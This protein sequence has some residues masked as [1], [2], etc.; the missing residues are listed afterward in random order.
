MTYSKE[1]FN[2]ID[3]L[4]STLRDVDHEILGDYFY[5]WKI[6][7]WNKISNE[8]K[9]YSPEFNFYGHKWKLEL[10]PNG[11]DDFY[12]GNISLYLYRD[13]EKDDCCV[14]IAVNRV[15]FIRNY[16]DYSCFHSATLPIEYLSKSIPSSGH[17]NLINKSQLYIK[18]E[19]LN[20]SLIE[21]NRCVLGVY[22]QIYKNEK[23]LF[24]REITCYVDDED[25]V[26]KDKGFYEWKVGNWNKSRRNIPEIS[27][28]FNVGDQRW[29]LEL[30]KDG[31]G[32][33]NKKYVS[34][35][36]KCLN[37]EFNKPEGTWVNGILFIRNCDDD[38]DC[39]YFDV[40]EFRNFNVNNVDWGFPKLIK[41]KELFVKSKSS[42]KSVIENDRC[43]V[44]AYFHIY[45]D[46][47]GKKENKAENQPS[48]DTQQILPPYQNPPPYS[49]STNTGTNQ[50]LNNA[51][52]PQ[53]QPYQNSPYP[54]QQGP[55]PPYQNPPYP[56]QQGP[57]PPYQYPP[58]YYSPVNNIPNQNINNAPIQQYPPYQN[59]P[60]Q[61]TPPMYNSFQN[62]PF[63]NNPFQNNLFQN[64]PFQNNPFQNASTR[65]APT[66]DNQE[67]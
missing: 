2:L 39:F 7:N 8:E 64:N 40:L 25:K 41:K 50:N 9:V 18:N 53:Y 62:N 1:Q 45:K 23:G 5:E 51:P 44:G 37:P 32:D 52:V 49:Y 21:N 16:D 33:A 12:K 36:L 42:N 48:S 46:G 54:V 3:K 26:V 57:V 66:S 59:P 20:K 29:R 43:I 24:K 35:F 10:Y 17:P 13:D 58:P 14:H 27:P 15:F 60:Y 34:I 19:Y 63:Q 4:K 31:D 11:V 38:T 47:K 30:Y 67:K 6:D 56:I 55:F 22:F 61:D 65:E 28:V